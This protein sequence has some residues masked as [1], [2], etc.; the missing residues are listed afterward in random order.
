MIAPDIV[1]LLRVLNIHSN[2]FPTLEKMAA[3]KAQL[4]S[5][6][7]KRGVAILNADDERVLAMGG[8]CSGTIRTFG[9]APG[10]FVTASEVSARWP[11]RLSFRATCGSE[12]AWVQTNLVGEHMVYS[13]L[14]ALTAAVCCG[15]PIGKAGACLQQVQPVPGRMQPMY[16]PN[17]VTVLR[18]EFNPTLSTLEAALDVMRSA[19]ASRRI[20]ILG[21]VL[22]SGR[23]ER[24]RA[25]YLGAQVAQAAEMAVFLGSRA[26]LAAKAA[27]AAGMRA[28]SAV[29]FKTL[30]EGAEFIKAELRAGDLVLVHGWS[31]RHIERV[32][33]AQLGSISCWLEQCNKIMRCEDC[34]E[35]KLVTMEKNPDSEGRNLV[36]HR[37]D[38]SQKNS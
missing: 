24:P 30:P 18:D 15:V 10:A 14:G 35:L 36:R 21:D 23:S 34:S 13:A 1:L 16:L 32:I 6:L 11:E 28:G 22:D 19:E 7:G 25:H 38:L 3:E 37:G 17:G 29:A 5:R 4:L 33:L 20:V 27:M 9:L 8:C 2:A 26:K 31:G 12:S